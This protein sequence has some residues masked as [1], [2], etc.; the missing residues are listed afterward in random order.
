MAALIA[1]N[2]GVRA[3]GNMSVNA[4]GDVVDSKNTPV[5]TRQQTV[6]AYYKKQISNPSPEPV[7]NPQQAA[8]KALTEDN[9]IAPVITPPA[10]EP[11]VFPD[12]VVE[13]DEIEESLADPVIDAVSKLDAVD[14]PLQP[15]RD[16]VEALQPTASPAPTGLAAAI[17]KV[18]DNKSLKD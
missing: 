1:K 8:V 15:L 7:V 16:V 11:V 14:Q 6:Q 5:K 17:Q 9:I 2:E 18:K 12:D 13:N 4:R 10:P 3:V